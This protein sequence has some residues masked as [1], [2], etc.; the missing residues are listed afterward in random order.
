MSAGQHG[1]EFSR[2]RLGHGVYRAMRLRPD[3]LVQL[4]TDLD[5]QV[6]GNVNPSAEANIFG[7]PEAADYVFKHTNGDTT[8][9]VGLDVT[10]DCVITGTELASLKGMFLCPLHIGHCCRN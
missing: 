8:F 1:H 2:I 10:H 9:V 4:M 6:S 3:L 5:I 7:D